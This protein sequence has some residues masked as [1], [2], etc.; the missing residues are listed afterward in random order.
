VG[1]APP[2][3]GLADSQRISALRGLF[4]SFVIA[5]AMIGLV[6]M[7]LGRTRTETGSAP[8]R[9]LAGL[10]SAAGVA[11]LF[12]PRLFARPLRCTDEADLVAS[13]RSR[14]FVRI[15]FAEAPALV[16]FAATV[17]SGESWLYAL[18]AFFAAV[19]FAGAAP[20]ATHL[21]QDQ[22]RG[23]EPD[24]VFSCSRRWGERDKANREF[25]GSQRNFADSGTRSSA[26]SCAPRRRRSGR[27]CRSCIPRH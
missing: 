16:A 10:V 15:A 26:L 13:Y 9:L 6:A 24:R 1:N 3:E 23:A 22:E 4:L 17:A 21:A 27:P 2:K 5:I 11:A 18:G 19:G 12:G 8:V 14:F 7:V 20:T 25:M